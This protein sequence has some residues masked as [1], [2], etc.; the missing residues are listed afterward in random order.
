MGTRYGKVPLP[1]FPEPP[2]PDATARGWGA[3]GMAGWLGASTLPAAQRVREFLNRSL[4]ALPANAAENLCHRLGGDPP[5]ERVFFEL[6]VGRFLQILGAAVRHQPAGVGGVNLDWRATFPDGQVA[7]VEAT[8]PAYNREGLHEVA[9]RQAMLAVIE[10]E[11][12]PGWWIA[13]GR[14]P[15]LGLHEARRDFRQAVRS[16]F[17]GSPMAPAIR[18]PTASAWR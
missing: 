5:F 6:L 15:R 1:C 10:T 18:S 2:I 12:P 8:S 7:F 16:M 13:P 17:R 4:D 3:I 14:L 11:A 9:R